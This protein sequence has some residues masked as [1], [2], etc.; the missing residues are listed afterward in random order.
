MPLLFLSCIIVAADIDIGITIIVADISIFILVAIAF[1]T[2]SAAADAVHS[3]KISIT[4]GYP[5]SDNDI[6]HTIIATIKDHLM[7]SNQKP[8]HL[9]N[10]KT[11]SI[12]IETAGGVASPSP[13]G[14]LQCDMLRPFATAPA[15]LV[16]DARLG[17]ISST[18]AAY[19]ML[20]SRGY[21]IPWIVLQE[22]GDGSLGNCKAIQQHV[23]VHGTR[24]ISFPECIGPPVAEETF[25]STGGAADILDTIPGIATK[26]INHSSINDNSTMVMVENEERS[27]GIDSA[28]TGGSRK[29]G[30]DMRPSD[31]QHGGTTHAFHRPTTTTI[32]AALD[33]TCDDSIDLGEDVDKNLSLWLESTRDLFD[34]LHHDIQ[35]HHREQLSWYHTAAQHAQHVFWWPFTQHGTLESNGELI[36]I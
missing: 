14:S 2:F 31:G 25:S 3:I 26:S 32:A 12:I 16:G 1:L 21:E 28:G 7:I 35:V 33:G 29:I 30:N 34:S 18:L 17:G 20:R 13:S 4:A 22:D 6:I 24:V 9:S 11:R 19:E 8:H 27:A 5:I 10:Q 36:L 23:D 15:L